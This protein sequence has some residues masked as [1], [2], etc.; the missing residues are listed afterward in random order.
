M[1][2]IVIKTPTVLT[3]ANNAGS[4]LSPKKRKPAAKKTSK[5]VKNEP[6]TA[7]QIFSGWSTDR[8]SI[9]TESAVELFENSVLVKNIATA[10]VE[11]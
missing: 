8:N 1:H 10:A 2:D 6:K 4:T 5:V 11:A 9:R 3:C 7:K